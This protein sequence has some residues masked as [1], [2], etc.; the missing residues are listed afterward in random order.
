MTKSSSIE[1]LEQ[2]I[3][4][5]KRTNM[6]LSGG[7]IFCVVLC[8]FCLFRVNGPIETRSVLLTDP[9]ES[10]VAE[11]TAEGLRFQDKDGNTVTS[12]SRETL[13]VGESSRTGKLHVKAS[14]DGAELTLGK[15][16]SGFAL[17]VIDSET[18]LSMTTGP[19]S[20]G[21]VTLAAE[22]S[23]SR[24]YLSEPGGKNTAWIMAMTEGALASLTADGKAT[25]K[26]P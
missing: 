10:R 7:L 22:D 24:L 9:D 5:L 21:E 16:G 23:G 3:D 1:Q 25:W 14:L 4:Q 20:K 19:E 8:V 26:A 17:R 6:L 15:P 13:L 11:L 2:S 18:Y 12:L